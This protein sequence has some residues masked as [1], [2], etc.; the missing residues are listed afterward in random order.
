MGI[1]IQSV[2]NYAPWIYAV[3]GL[4]ALYQI[5]RIWQVRAERKQA[6]F[7]LEREKA[8]RDT[9]N[10]FG[11]AL[12]L[13]VTMGFTYFVSTTLASAV[14]P[15]VSEALAPTP[16]L[17]FVP[18]PTNTPLLATPTPTWTPTPDP[19]AATRRAE[20]AVGPTPT[21][22]QEPEPEAP[23]TATPA[24]VV[25]APACADSKAVLIRP[26]QNEVVRGVVN[27]IGTATHENFQY[28]KLE[29]APGAGAGNGFVYVGGGTSPVVA[30][31]LAGLDTSAYA[32]GAW[33][34]RLIV[35]DQTGNFPPPCQV[36]I[37]VQN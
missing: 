18:T 10:I 3:C 30:G 24:P 14:D 13:V 28:Y 16:A 22:A 31:V 33:T 11:I 1:V 2:A 20:E 35:V 4:V 23:P 5:Y 27:V 34:L 29:L 8:I 17:P 15:L 7:S 19:L 12:V 21:P 9:Y 32:N 36:T 6:V 37:T 25:Q 26:G